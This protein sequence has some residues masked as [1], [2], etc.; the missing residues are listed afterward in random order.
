MYNSL[1]S[2]PRYSFL[3]AAYETVR[4]A[5]SIYFDITDELLWK[6]KSV[7]KS[8]LAELREFIRQALDHII[9]TSVKHSLYI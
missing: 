6:S 5:R 8:Q 1:A 4:F 2:S 3:T 7:I 9:I